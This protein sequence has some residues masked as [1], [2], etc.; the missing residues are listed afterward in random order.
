MENVLLLLDILIRHESWIVILEAQT[1]WPWVVNEFEM[2]S[3]SLPYRERYRCVRESFT[4]YMF[5]Y[6][7]RKGSSYYSWDILA[8]SHTNFLHNIFHT[9][10]LPI[11]PEVKISF[12]KMFSSLY[13]SLCTYICTC[14]FFLFSE[15][16]YRD[17]GKAIACL[18]LLLKEKQTWLGVV[19]PDRVLMS[20]K[21]FVL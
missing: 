18:L 15:N 14:T 20:R 12:S 1:T 3:H 7:R 6:L 8:E 5:P 19:Y 4:I 11:Y 17:V 2:V 16:V 13:V 10:T 21:T 9:P